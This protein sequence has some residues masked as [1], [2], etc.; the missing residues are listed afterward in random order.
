MSGRSVETG[1]ATPPAA[2]F[3]ACFIVRRV[4]KLTVRKVFVWK[5][6]TKNRIASIQMDPLLKIAALSMYEY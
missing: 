4:W 6:Q 1:G 2:I 5:R 3:A